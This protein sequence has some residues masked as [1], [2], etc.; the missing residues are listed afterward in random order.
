MTQS[1]LLT[2]KDKIVCMRVYN[3]TFNSNDARHFLDIRDDT[4]K[5]IIDDRTVIDTQV[6]SEEQ[7]AK[8]NIIINYSQ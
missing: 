3:Y 8:Q 5:I 4:S 1:I 2:P 6:L 7:E